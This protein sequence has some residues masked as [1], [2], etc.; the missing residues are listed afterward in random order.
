LRYLGAAASIPLHQGSDVY[1]L[2]ADVAP[3]TNYN[4]P[5]SMIA[6][7]EPG[8]YGDLWAIVQDSQQI[9]Q[10]WVYITVQ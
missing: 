1:D 5:V 6:P 8:N 9:C 7:Y 3:G 4:F 2:M 10:F